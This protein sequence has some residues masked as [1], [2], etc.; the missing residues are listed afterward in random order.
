MKDDSGLAIEAWGLT[1]RYRQLVAVD[2]VNF[3]VSKGEIFGFLGPNGASKTTTV[4][5]LTGVIRPDEGKALIM[6][7]QAGSLGAK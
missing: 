6:G 4:R 1:K 3:A 2:H 5:M 7:H